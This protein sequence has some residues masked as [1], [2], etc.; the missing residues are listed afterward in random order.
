MEKT[1]LRRGAG[2][3]A[4]AVVA[5]VVIAWAAW[6]RPL[7]VEAARCRRGAIT[8]AVAEE[9]ETRLER[10]Y[11]VAMPVGGRLLR[12]DL[13]EGE[14]VEAGEVVARV[15]TFER[16]ERL[17]ELRARVEETR[18]LIVGVDME[19]PKPED[20]EAA[21]IA[22]KRAELSA[23]S[24]R[25]ASSPPALTTSRKSATTSERSSSAGR[26]PSPR[27]SSTARAPGPS[28]SKTTARRPG[29]PSSPPRRISR[30]RR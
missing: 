15:D 1:V 25:K 17:K 24:A 3:A 2:W 5:V 10:D 18:A 22:V 29:S 19:K 30:R 13:D 16:R 14:S 21:G 6:P 9:A 4:A 27:P 8:A 12:V 11:T 23:L 20:I 28:P 7:T 26:T